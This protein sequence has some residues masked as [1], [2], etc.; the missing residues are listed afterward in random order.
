MRSSIWL[1]L[2]LLG[3][4]AARSAQAQD[5]CGTNETLPDCFIRVYHQHLTEGATA[6][7]LDQIRA[8]PTGIGSSGEDFGTAKTDFLSPLSFAI[9]SAKLEDNNQRLVIA[10]NLPRFKTG[11]RPV[12]QLQSVI[13]QAQ[14]F[15]PLKKALNG[16]GQ[17]G[18]V[19]DL[20]QGL[21]DLDDVSTVLVVSYEGT[22]LGRVFS[23]NWASFSTVLEGTS[24]N[25]NADAARDK[26]NSRLQEIASLIPNATETNDLTIRDLPEKRRAD[27]ENSFLAA[28]RAQAEED[29]P[30]AQ[31]LAG[32]KLAEFKELVDNQPQLLATLSWRQ[33]DSLVGPNLFIAQVSYEWNRFSLN[34]F[35]SLIEPKGGTAGLKGAAALEAFDKYVKEHPVKRSGR[36]KF[37]A[38]Y[39]QAE[40]YEARPD[41]SFPNGLDRATRVSG[42]A[43][44]GRPLLFDGKGDETARIDFV[45]KYEDFSDDP[46]HEDRGTASLTYTQKLSDKVELPIGLTY[47]NHGEFLG[48]VDKRFSAHFGLTLKAFN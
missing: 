21:N 38:E 13:R 28:A 18:R 1:F 44:Y 30:L 25:K 6:G 27:F 3:I 10:W 32:G 2:L 4:L 34:H 36:W 17:T 7:L 24:F 22:R 43:T 37:S 29:R 39:T 15:S 23:P 14:L 16:A 12:F 26:S 35:R 48:D 11:S 42:S 8:R 5:H 33:R 20:E 41:L 45:G 40:E 47:A 19:G 9:Q 46:L 31:F